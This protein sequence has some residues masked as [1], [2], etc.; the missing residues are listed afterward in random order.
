MLD[1]FVKDLELAGVELLILDSAIS[2]YRPPSPE[3]EADE[4]EGKSKSD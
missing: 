1:E 2:A 4:K 3:K